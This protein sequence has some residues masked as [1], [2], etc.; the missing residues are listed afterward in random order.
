MVLI[1]GKTSDMFFGGLKALFKG[2]KMVGGVATESRD[3]LQAVVDLAAR[4]V[5]KPVID[6]N[7]AFADMKA[8]HAQVDTGHKRGNVVVSVAQLPETAKVA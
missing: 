2:R 1:A 6:R 3:I 8:V 5:F 7:Y 4:G